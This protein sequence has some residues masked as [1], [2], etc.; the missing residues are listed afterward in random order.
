MKQRSKRKKN[1]NDN[2]QITHK[3]NKN[4]TT[5]AVKKIW[6]LTYYF[7][8]QKRVTTIKMLDKNKNK[9]KTNLSDYIIIC[10]D[11]ESSD[12]DNIDYAPKCENMINDT[13]S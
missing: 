11:T 13:N 1:N 3:S 7:S 10:D 4:Y 2:Q 8:I 9:T 5:V 12:N 6:D